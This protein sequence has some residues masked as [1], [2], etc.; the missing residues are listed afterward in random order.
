M[1]PATGVCECTGFLGPALGGG[2]GFTQSLYG[3]AIDNFISARVLLGNGTL[4]NVSEN[5]HADL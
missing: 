5:E 2:H 3:L 4:V 1:I